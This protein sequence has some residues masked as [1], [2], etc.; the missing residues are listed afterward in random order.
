MIITINDLMIFGLLIVYALW[1]IFDS[2]RDIKQSRK[3]TCFVYCPR[4]HNEL[5]SSESFVEDHDGIVEY[6]CDKCGEVS[7]WDFAHYPVPYLLEYDTR[8]M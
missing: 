6:K 8:T 4:C 5:V 2:L 7:F 1:F 3:Q